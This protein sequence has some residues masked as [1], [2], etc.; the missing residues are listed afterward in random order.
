MNGK[1]SSTAAQYTGRRPQQSQLLPSIGT[2]DTRTSSAPPYSGLLTRS[3]SLP[4]RPSTFYQS[5]RV[6]PTQLLYP[7]TTEPFSASNYLNNLD[8]AKVAP[9]LP[10]ARQALYTRYTPKDWHNAQLTNFLASDKTR[11]AAERLRSNTV[12]LARDKEEQAYKNN[13]E[14][15]K[16]LAE[17]VTEIE[18]WKDELEK[19]KEKMNRKLADIDSSR[20]EIER[21]LADTER[22][23]R[24]AQ[25]NLYEREKR[26][27]Q[28]EERVEW[29]ARSVLIHFRY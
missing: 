29:T 7:S 3:V 5:A 14:S 8:S 9:L 25:E 12:R 1:R 23:L 13:A 26:Q 27:G 4:W 19:T 2:F 6:E 28:P 15:S 24:I 11:S 18:Y 16:R 17:R 10:S 20:R 21:Q 22:P